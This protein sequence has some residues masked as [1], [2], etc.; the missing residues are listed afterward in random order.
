MDQVE[1]YGV[2]VATFLMWGGLC[3]WLV[4]R[5]SS[6]LTLRQLF[7]ILTGFAVIAAI[8]APGGQEFLRTHRNLSA[9]LAAF[10]IISF[11]FAIAA[12]FAFA[13]FRRF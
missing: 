12:L 5:R 6:K 2:V 13:L 8:A 4:W 7:V 3:A 1:N 9:S 10:S 11:T